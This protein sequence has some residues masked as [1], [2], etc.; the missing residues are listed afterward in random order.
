MQSCFDALGD[1]RLQLGADVLGDLVL[2]LRLQYVADFFEDPVLLLTLQ[3][4][5]DFLE[6]GHE[7]SAHLSIPAS[8]NATRAL[9]NNKQHMP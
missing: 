9:P 5:V 4:G 7:V 2:L 3:T 1:L 6:S 8:T